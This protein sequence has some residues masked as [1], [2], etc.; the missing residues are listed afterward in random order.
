MDDNLTLQT[1]SA[2]ERI[3]EALMGKT[4]DDLNILSLHLEELLRKSKEIKEVSACLI[5]G[6]C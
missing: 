2:F 1:A 4:D 6:D 3:Y 5:S